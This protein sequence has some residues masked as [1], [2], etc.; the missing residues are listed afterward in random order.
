MVVR[1]V[2]TI[3]QEH[4]GWPV[5]TVQLRVGALRAV[6][7]VS[8]RYCYE[9]SA[10]GTR[11]EGSRLE[12]EIALTRARCRACEAEFPVEDLAF[13]C[14]TCGCADCETTAGSELL[15]DWIEFE[16]TAAGTRGGGGGPH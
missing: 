10:Q 14:P 16:D 9:A 13:V 1:E 6:N 7:P 11:A 2:E 12:V 4:P 5:R 8:L 15:L 3:A